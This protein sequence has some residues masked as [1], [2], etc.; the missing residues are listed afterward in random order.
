MKVYISNYRDHWL[1]PYTILEHI[2]FWRVYDQ[3]DPVIER[4]ASRLE[5][6]MLWIQKILDR[7]HPPIRYVKIDHYD[8]WG[9]DHT[10][11]HIILPMLKQ[12]KATQHGSGQVDPED[13]PEHLR[14]TDPPGPSNGYT[15]NTV[16]ERWTW[17]LDEM[18]WAFEQKVKDDD[19]AE[20]Y[21]HSGVDKTASLQQQIAQIKIDRTAMEVHQKR[22]QNAYRLFGK[23]YQS[24]WD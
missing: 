7:V 20:F 16:H 12:L 9:M 1:S 23:Y 8:T 2:C 19:E 13:V 17:I 14:P 18:I 15:D 5:P 24:L 21:D 10:L 6:I 4:W 11:A 3:D 22:K